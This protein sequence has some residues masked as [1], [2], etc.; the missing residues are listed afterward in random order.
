MDPNTQNEI[1]SNVLLNLTKWQCHWSC[2]CMHHILID[3]PVDLNTDLP[4]SAL[5]RPFNQQPAA[6]WWWAGWKLPRQL[7]GRILMK[8]LQL[9]DLK[10]NLQQRSRPSR[11]GLSSNGFWERVPARNQKLEN[12]ITMYFLTYC[13]SPISSE[14]PKLTS[15]KIENA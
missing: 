11:P 2:T 12:R 1:F 7:R 5:S 13:R 9:K 14:W 15:L 8:R 3:I 10:E 6:K 4:P